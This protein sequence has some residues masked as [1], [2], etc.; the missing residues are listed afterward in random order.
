M[1]DSKK[2]IF[3]DLTISLV[4]YKSEAQI[5]KLINTLSQEISIIVIDNDQNLE[6][7]NY[8]MNNF[9]NIKCL[10]PE[11]NLGFGAGLNFAI[12]NTLTDYILHLDCDV[13]ITNNDIAKLITKAKNTPNF[14]VI[15][16]KLNNQKYDD[17]IESYDEKNKMYKVS[18]NTGC[19][20]LFKKSDV[21]EVG[22]FDENFF[23][24][25]E[26]HD[27]YKR[28]FNLGKPLYLYDDV[29]IE[30]IGHSSI[31]E[32]SRYDY[33]ICRNWHYCWSK[34]YYFKKHF[35]YFYAFKKTVPNLFSAIKN[36]LRFS[37]IGDFYKAKL[38]RAEFFGL[39]NSYLLRKSSYRMK[40]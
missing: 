13:K 4:S 2:S 28:C 20:M 32:D 36:L 11:E 19:A 34:F 9:R 27:Y 37:F 15:T 22:F 14:G 26:E 10:F 21:H 12:K 31:R 35:N 1:K 6:F 7:K 5:K 16:P 24:Y 25:F 3:S 8:L 17:L 18:F 30:H 33:L 23:L 40:K 39:M 29:I 38:Y